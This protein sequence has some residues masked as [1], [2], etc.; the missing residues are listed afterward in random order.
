VLNGGLCAG[1]CT[2]GFNG[3]LNGGRLM[4]LPPV[5]GRDNNEAW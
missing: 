2:D 4:P 5:N 1:H 3:W